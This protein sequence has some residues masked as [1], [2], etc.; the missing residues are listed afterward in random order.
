MN[1]LYLDSQYMFKKSLTAMTQLLRKVEGQVKERGDDEQA[2]L[3]SRLIEDMFPLVKQVQVMSDNAKGAMARLSGVDAPIMEDNETTFSELI[4]RLE[5]TLEFVNSVTA[6]ALEGADDRKIVIAY[7]PGKYQTAE[8]YIRD[9]ALP[10]FY[11]HLVTAYGILRMN[12]YDIG[13]MDFA[14][15]LNL[16]D[17]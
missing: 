16:R 15:G 11:F 12:G 17:L 10:N 2:L 9:Y 1:K 7:M 6:E 8:D 4:T 14:G 13:K 3:Q 5:K